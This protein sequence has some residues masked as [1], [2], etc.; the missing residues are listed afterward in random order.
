[1]KLIY[2]WKTFF[3]YFFYRIARLNLRFTKPDRAI[4][5]VTGVQ[6]LLIMNLLLVIYSLVFPNDRRS[7]SGYEIIILLVIFFTID[8]FNVK[9]YKGRYE[10]LDRRWENE[11]HKKKTIGM[12]IVIGFI[13]FC[14]GLLFITGFIFDRFKKY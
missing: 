14:F 3:E 7:F 6:F 4:T 10:E 12:F 11:S 13:I 8:Y 5:S 2:I 1:M 9:T